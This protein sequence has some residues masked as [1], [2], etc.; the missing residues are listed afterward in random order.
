MSQ[1][2][3]Q[4]KRA[5]RSSK[6]HAAAVKRG[7]HCDGIDQVAVAPDEARA[8]AGIADWSDDGS[9][10]DGGTDDDCGTM[11]P[12]AG[13]KA[14]A[15]S[16]GRASANVAAGAN[17]AAGAGKGVGGG[18]HVGTSSSG[19]VAKGRSGAGVGERGSDSEDDFQ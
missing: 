18:K 16:G 10:D 17:I 19:G 11:A 14:G 3:R 2:P 12:V 5:Y 4:P 8:G 1:H 15:A 13:A 9:S 7:K 6:A